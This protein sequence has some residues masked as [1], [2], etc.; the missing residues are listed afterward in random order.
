MS[1]CCWARESSAGGTATTENAR[2][3]AGI[4]PAGQTA[5][6][7]LFL[8]DKTTNLQ[9]TVLSE[10]RQKR[11]RPAQVNSNCIVVN[12][13]CQASR[14]GGAGG[15]PRRPGPRRRQS[16]RPACPRAPTAPLRTGRRRKRP[17]RGWCAPDRPG[18]AHRSA[19]RRG[20]SHRAHQRKRGAADV[21]AGIP[22]RPRQTTEFPPSW[23]SDRTRCRHRKSRSNWSRRLE[24]IH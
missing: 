17:P 8:A 10:R 23:R 2:H 5:A 13:R 19:A 11:R 1:D 3:S 24:P 20:V 15:S 16:Q 18:R 6:A 21:A 14:A 22:I 4:Y 9:Q 7:W 12:C